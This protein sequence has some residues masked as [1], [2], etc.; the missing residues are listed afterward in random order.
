MTC[1]YSLNYRGELV[2]HRDV[3]Y[4]ADDGFG[5]HIEVPREPYR[6]ATLEET[7]KLGLPRNFQIAT[8]SYSFAM[9]DWR[10]GWG[11]NH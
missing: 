7:E 2:Q 11:N 6:L 3:G 1:T 10:F 8:G 9:T 5:N 4:L